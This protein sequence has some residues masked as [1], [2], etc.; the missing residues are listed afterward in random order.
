[1]ATKKDRARELEKELFDAQADLKN[2]Q[3][4]IYAKNASLSIVRNVRNSTSY[5]L[6]SSIP[7]SEDCLL[8]GWQSSTHGRTY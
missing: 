6:F 1:M 3:D 7:S 5:S 2:A 8:L 4:E